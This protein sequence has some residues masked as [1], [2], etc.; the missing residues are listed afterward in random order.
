MEL[1]YQEKLFQAPTSCETGQPPPVSDIQ[2]E[3]GNA[4][5]PLA[6]RWR[7]MLRHVLRSREL[8]IHRSAH[9]PGIP[10]R[11][12]L[13]ECL[14]GKIRCLISFFSGNAA[15]FAVTLQL[16]AAEL[17]AFSRGQLAGIY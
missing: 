6:G 12:A 5:S 11:L 14:Y 1:R 8:E 16:A 4:A 17:V 9:K 3:Q 13:A 2:G 10:S 15:T 7:D